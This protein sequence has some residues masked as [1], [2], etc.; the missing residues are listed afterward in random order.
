[1]VL[2]MSSQTRRR[3]SGMSLIE[4][5][6]AVVLIGVIAVSL[7]PLFTR[8]VRQNREGG[9]YT[10]MTNVARSTL[11]QFGQFDFNA[12]QLTLAAGTTEKVTNEYLDPATKRWVTFVPPAVP[13]TGAFYQRTVQVQQYS[14]GDLLDNGSLDSP[15]DGAVNRDNVQLK[16]IRVSV[17]PL[18]GGTG[19]SGALLGKRTP[20]AI[21]L[22]KAI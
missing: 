3:E 21:E 7:V 16:L 9:N 11:E 15:Q 18:W 6:I 14:A 8:S 1:M 2:T 19:G 13:P 12:P 5:L 17:R 22:L 4:V 20:I 10:E